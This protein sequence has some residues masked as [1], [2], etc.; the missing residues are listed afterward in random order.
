MGLDNTLSRPL[1]AAE[2]LTVVACKAGLGASLA[3]LV[4]WGSGDALPTAGVA[5]GLMAIGAIGY[6]ASLALYLAAQR[7]LGAGRTGSVFAVGPFVGALMAIGLGDRELSWLTA[8]AALLFAVGVWLHI[9][10]RHSHAHAHPALEHDH[11]HRHDDAHHLHVHDG[12]V[13]AAGHSHV[14]R[15]EALVHD[16]AHAPDLHHTHRH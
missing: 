2:P 9:E 6:G 7:H 4:G 14:H 10:E 5:L 3:A 12:P 1:S 8:V 15:H 11:F 13:A 16:H